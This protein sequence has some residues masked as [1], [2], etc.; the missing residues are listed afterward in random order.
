[1]KSPIALPIDTSEIST[2][3]IHCTMFICLSLLL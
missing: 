1:M 2:T 3:G